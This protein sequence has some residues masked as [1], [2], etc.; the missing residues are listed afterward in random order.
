MDSLLVVLKLKD[1][2]LRQQLVS[3]IELLVLRD[4]ESWEYLKTITGV[5]GLL[6]LMIAG[7][8]ALQISACSTIA[9]E[10]VND[11]PYL[12]TLLSKGALDAVLQLLQSVHLSV[13]LSALGFLKVLISI[14]I[15]R[16]QVLKPDYMCVLGNLL[17]SGDDLSC[18]QAAC[19]IMTLLGNDSDIELRRSFEIS[20]YTT[21]SNLPP[22]NIVNRLVDMSVGKVLFSTQKNES[23]GVCQEDYCEPMLIQSVRGIV[24]TASNVLAAATDGEEAEWPDGAPPLRS[25]LKNSGILPSLQK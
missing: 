19:E 3:A 10:S 1:N 20:Q 12:E 9:T 25:T 18:I 8:V 6:T 7:N 4:I 15:G 2:E 21:I 16:V 17:N 22:I 23:Y 5:D 11:L 14:R 13:K 24:L